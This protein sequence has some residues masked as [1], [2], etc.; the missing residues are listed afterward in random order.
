[1]YINEKECDAAGISI[2]DANAIRKRLNRIMA[3]AHKIG[4]SLF[5]GGGNTLRADDGKGK[6]LIIANL[7]FSNADGGDGG[8]C[9]G[10]D[11]LLRGE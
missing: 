1:M 9:R 5:C 7:D 3:D 4:I 2:Y 6:Q 11:G 8:Y 10:D